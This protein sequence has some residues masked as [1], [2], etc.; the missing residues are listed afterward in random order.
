LTRQADKKEIHVVKADGS[1]Q[2][3][4]AKFRDLEPGDSIIV[5]PKQEEKV[6]T[7]P[8]IRDVVQT[9]GS[10]LLSFAALAVLF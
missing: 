10:A 8:T 9:V 2:A 4:F 1:A 3:G 5:P 7:L 6:R